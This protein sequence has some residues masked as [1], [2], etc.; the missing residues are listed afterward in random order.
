MLWKVAV[1]P[2]ILYIRIRGE[3]VR[4]HMKSIG[5]R[6]ERREQ[7]KWG[8][9]WDWEKSKRNRHILLFH[10]RVQDS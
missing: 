7:A 8:N 2:L 9:L 1:S 5:D 4:G 3:E 10:R 6:L